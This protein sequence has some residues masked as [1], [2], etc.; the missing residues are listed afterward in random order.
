MSIR[1]FFSAKLLRQT[2]IKY[3]ILLSIISFSFFLGSLFFGQH[4]LYASDNETYAQSF[5]VG[6]SHTSLFKPLDGVYIDTS[7]RPKLVTIK[8]S[9][10]STKF[11][12]V[13]KTVRDAITLQG[14]PFDQNDISSPNPDEP[15]LTDMTITITYV[16]KEIVEEAVALPF[17]TTYTIAN[18]IYVGQTKLTQPGV[19]GIQ[20][21]IYEVTTHDGQEAK[22]ELI[23][24]Y[25]E[26]DPIEEIIAKGTKLNGTSTCQSWDNVIDNMTDD[27]IERY[28]M[29]SVMRCESHCNEKVVSEIGAYKG[30]YQFN[31]STFTSWGGQDIFDGTEQISLTLKLFR[32]GYQLKWPVCSRQAYSTM[33]DFSNE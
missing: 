15:I 8:G 17:M 7:S 21:N 3:F 22:K 14:I 18:D 31:S 28:W 6:I 25:I 16:D 1:R 33:P 5:K 4:L 9:N 29:K 23:D 11:L 32:L 2:Q 20:K 19:M 24:S 12:T 27:P 10:F 30:L 13:S 26:K